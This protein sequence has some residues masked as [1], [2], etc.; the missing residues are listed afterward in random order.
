MPERHRRLDRGRLPTVTD[1]STV[2]T[3]RPLAAA[4]FDQLDATAED[5]R[6]VHEAL[7]WASEFLGSPNAD[8]GRKGPVCPHIRNCFT[9]GLIYVTSRPETGCAGDDLRTAIRSAKAWFAPLQEQAPE[10]SEHLVTILVV[11]PRIDRTSSAGLDA[12]HASMKDEF[13]SQGLMLGQFHPRCGARGLWNADFRPLQSPVPLLAIREMVASDLPFLV[14][15]RAHASV[16]FQ[17]YARAIP[18]HTRRFLVERLVGP[19]EVP[20]C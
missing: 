7:A 17:R 1:L 9:Q 3:T 12:L 4:S 16:Y 10:G 20:P 6:A 19:T 8:L 13:V 5:L 14:G 2:R 18:E 11:L 15:S